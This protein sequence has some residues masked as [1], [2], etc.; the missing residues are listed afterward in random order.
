M[1]H[2]TP[3][4][5]RLLLETRSHLQTIFRTS[6]DIVILACSGTGAMEAAVANLLTT[7]DQ[8]LAVVAG[9]FGQRWM[10]ICSAHGIDCRPLCKEH[11]EAAPA[12]EIVEA[13]SRAPETRA[14]LLQG[15]ETS[16]GTSHDVQSI[17]AAVRSR[18]P[19]VLIVVDAITTLACEPLET[20]AWDLDVVI[21]GS[22]KSFAMSP[23]LAFL[24]LSR[25]AQE[26]MSSARCA[27]Y[28]FDLARE[29]EKQRQ[30][31]T[32]FTSAVSLIEALHASAAEIVT[33]GLDAVIADAERMARCCRV[34]LRALGF[35]LLSKS[36][37]N[38]VTAV[39]P[40]AGIDAA[41]LSRE[42][43]QGFGIKVAGGQAA[44]KGKILRLAHLGYFDLLDVFSVLGAVELTLQ[45]L[46]EGPAP[47][48]GVGA[49]VQ[50][51]VRASNR[52]D[53][54]PA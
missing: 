45:S 17:A 25:R 32:A 38:A 46:G 41:M 49:A 27:P 31:E 6:G 47:G 11:G 10:D 12:E 16:T 28:Y 5:R 33:Q 2:R 50:E 8:A 44:L 39:Y 22:Q 20:E 15:C 48:T 54:T 29:V 51:A 40:P 21:G 18:F 19:E 43:E 26:Q 37:A 9:K 13:L 35:Q 1:H 42:L 24:S 14:L 4:F 7:E 53:A 36:P 23:G 52:S 3:E 30:G 34:G